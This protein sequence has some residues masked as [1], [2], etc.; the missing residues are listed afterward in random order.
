MMLGNLD[1]DNVFLTYK[2][3][4]G[5]QAVLTFLFFAYA[6]LMPII[7]LNLLVRGE[8]NIIVSFEYKGPHEV[9]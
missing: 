3:N 5:K 6:L 8:N 2:G 4:G 9:K 7:F 1:Y